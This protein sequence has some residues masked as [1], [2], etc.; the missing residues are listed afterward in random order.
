MHPGLAST[1][2]PASPVKSM[3][4]GGLEDDKQE[5]AFEQALMALRLDDEETPKKTNV[6]TAIE[7]QPPGVDLLDDNVLLEAALSNPDLFP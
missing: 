7:S 5:D 1:K 2:P 3:V 4:N 6:R